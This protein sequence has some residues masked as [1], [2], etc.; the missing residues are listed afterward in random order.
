MVSVV[1][2][3]QIG[4]FKAADS[5]QYFLVFTEGWTKKYGPKEASWDA[6]HFGDL[7]STMACGIKLAAAFFSGDFQG[8]GGRKT[9][10]AFLAQF[11][12]ALAN[13]YEL[14][15][16]DCPCKVKVGDQFFRSIKSKWLPEI[17]QILSAHG[18][19]AIG[20]ESALSLFPHQHPQAI[21]D[22][23]D[24]SDPK[25]AW[26][27]KNI[28]CWMFFSDSDRYMLTQPSDHAVTVKK[29]KSDVVVPEVYKYNDR[30]WFPET[31]DAAM[32]FKD[33]DY[34]VFQKMV[35]KYAVESEKRIPGS[36]EDCI[37]AIMANVENPVHVKM[38]E[39]S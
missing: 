16:F 25:G 39:A 22:I 29:A 21:Q 34:V 32:Q 24:L 9:P 33:Y 11:R 38:S 3:I 4:T 14:P 36:A 35:S 17:E 37:K 20:D 2:K 6:M 26:D 30:Y 19:P 28:P 1:R 8:P 15:H 13:A 5:K 7:D 10:T 12:K 27:E 18:L 31:E 23:L